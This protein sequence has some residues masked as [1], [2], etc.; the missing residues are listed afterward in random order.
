MKKQILPSLIAALFLI[1]ALNASATDINSVIEK[2][3]SSDMP[4]LADD[5]KN[6]PKICEALKI[7]ASTILQIVDPQ[8]ASH[9]LPDKTGQS[10]QSLFTSTAFKL[11]DS[12]RLDQGHKALSIAKDKN[13]EKLILGSLLIIA[14]I[15]HEGN[16]VF[17]QEALSIARKKNDQRLILEALLIN[18]RIPRQAYT[19][20]LDL[21]TEAL[22]IAREL[23]GQRLILDALLTIARIPNKN[24]LVLAHEALSIAR[25]INDQR[26]I[27]DAYLTIARIPHKEQLIRAQEALD[28]AN[29]LND[30][31][32]ILDALLTIARTPHKGN[33]T[34][35][36]EA[37]SIARKINDQRLILDTLLTVARIPHEGD[38]VLA[39][40]ALGIA[41]KLNDQ[42][43]ILDALLAIARIPHEGNLVFALEALDIARKLNDQRLIIDTLLT[44]ARIPHE[45]NLVLAQEALSLAERLGCRAKIEAANRVKLNIIQS[46]K[47][48][49]NDANLH[50]NTQQAALALP[51]PQ[52]IPQAEQF[53]TLPPQII[54]PFYAV[55]LAQ[56]PFS[57]VPQVFFPPSFMFAQPFYVAGQMCI[58]PPHYASSQD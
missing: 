47:T 28:F 6:E 12:T 35:A 31:R 52:A 33:L 10:C 21:A 40:E 16:L 57:C 11:D 38:L 23:N 39:R 37:L 29:E 51:I 42:R 9:A 3:L 8:V 46:K 53:R 49:C 43:L 54:P 34:P 20:R 15:P 50:A 1:N 56:Q 13:D 22:N 32:L 17:A 36:Q 26:L 48:P 41:R 2:L 45:G 18:A 55:S 25:K 14:R 7:D 19:I 44:T 24:D 5:Q 30:Q 58:Y 27:F 4:M